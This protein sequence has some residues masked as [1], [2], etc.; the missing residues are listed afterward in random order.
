ML[1]TWLQTEGTAERGEGLRVIKLLRFLGP[2]S[3]S[4]AGHFSKIYVP[5]FVT[6]VRIYVWNLRTLWSI[7]SSLGA[8][9]ESLEAKFAE[10]QVQKRLSVY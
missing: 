3:L 4:T 5:K 8:K 1:F 6:D 9:F 10:S 7:F 2:K